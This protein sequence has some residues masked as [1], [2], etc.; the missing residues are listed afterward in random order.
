MDYKKNIAK[1]LLK[2]GAFK[3]SFD[4]LFTWT[5]G[6]KSPVYCDLRALISDVDARSQIIS[7]FLELLPAGVD[8]IA[9]I[10]IAGIP[11]AAWI[12]EKAALPMVYVRSEAKEHGTKRRIEGILSAGQKVVLIED[13]I[14]TGKSS[15][16]AIAALREEAGAVVEN[17]LAINTYELAAA[18]KVYEEIGVVIS[19]ITNYSTILEVAQ[20]SGL[21]DSTNLNTLLEFKNNL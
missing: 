11:W 17:V 18:K 19:T 15:V 7:A 20:E 14:S 16:S 12:A 8:V 5:S 1:S 6:I 10:A 2:A 9:G 3:I 13:H 21:I 4:P